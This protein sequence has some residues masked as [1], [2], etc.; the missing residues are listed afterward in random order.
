MSCV[1]VGFSRIFLLGILIF[2]GLNA[3]RLYKSFGVKGLSKIKS[4]FLL[5][6]CYVFNARWL[7]Y[8]ESVFFITR[9]RYTFRVVC[10]IHSDLFHR[11]DFVTVADYV[12]TLRYSRN[13]MQYL[14]SV[15]K[16]PTDC[17][18]VFL[19][20]LRINVDYFPVHY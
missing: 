15:L 12:Y 11:L 14:D 19:C 20:I 3:G 18:Y 1:F 2:K 8:L 10:E 16:L 6:Y 13:V 9:R 7:L 4:L 17:T 5:L